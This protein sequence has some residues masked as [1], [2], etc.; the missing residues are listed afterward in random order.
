MQWR[1]VQKFRSRLVLIFSKIFFLRTNRQ[2]SW[3][4][5]LHAKTVLTYSNS[6]LYH[7]NDS[8][9]RRNEPLTNHNELHT[10]LHHPNYHTFS[11]NLH[12]LPIILQ[13]YNWPKTN[14]G[15]QNQL[16]YFY[17]PWPTILFA[18]F[19]TYTNNNKLHRIDSFFF[20]EFDARF[21]SA[22]L[23]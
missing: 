13:R 15:P 7:R 4:I 8:S 1:C 19:R 14:R 2:D 23:P 9:M 3:Q 10:E 17:F 21:N 16:L 11:E 5:I 18:I 6:I 20:V 12:N 22:P